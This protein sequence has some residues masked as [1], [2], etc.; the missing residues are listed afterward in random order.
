MMDAMLQHVLVKD[1]IIQLVSCSTGRTMKCDLTN[2]AAP[3]LSVNGREEDES[4]LLYS[5]SVCVAI[6]LSLHNQ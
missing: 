3:S 2:K 4:I 6:L 5:L 1:A